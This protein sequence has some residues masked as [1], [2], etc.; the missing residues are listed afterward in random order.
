MKIVDAFWEERN[1][2]VT[3]Y[4]LELEASDSLAEVAAE[5]DGLTQR[6][7][8]VAKIPSVRFDLVQLFQSKGYSFIE[9]SIKLEL[10]FKKL[11]YKPPEFPDRLQKICEKCSCEIMDEADLAQ[12]SAEI[13]KNMFDTDRIFIDPV[14][15][16]EQAA[17]RYDLWIKDLIKQGDIPYKVV[18]DNKTVGFFSD[19]TISPKLSQGVLGGVYADYRDTGMGI[20]Y[21]YAHFMFCLERGIKKIV[22][23]VSSNNPEVL[24][25]HT[26]FG[27]EIKRLAYVFIKHMG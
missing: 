4:E 23:S 22:T 18:L 21:N 1:L 8:M 7:Y 20:V 17:R 13:K 6:Q 15:T 26:L 11:G 24:R 19:K 25:L 16:K 3:C 9:T 5:L 27:A 10:N 14:F 12:L 2:G